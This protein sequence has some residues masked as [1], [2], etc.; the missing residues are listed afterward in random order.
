M[1]EHIVKSNAARLGWR[2]ILDAARAG[3]DTVIEHYDKPTAAVIPYADFVALKDKLDGL[4]AARRGQEALSAERRDPQSGAP[5]RSVP[6][7]DQRES[8]AAQ[9]AECHPLREPKIT[10]ARASR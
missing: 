3:S 7:K 6:A 5:S 1:A 2:D 9:T 8:V 4:R 10:I